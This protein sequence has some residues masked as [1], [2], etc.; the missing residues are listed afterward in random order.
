MTKGHAAMKHFIGLDAHSKT[1]MFVAVDGRGRQTM[2]QRVKTGE[3]AILDV[4]R[5]FSGKKALTFEESHLSKWLYTLLKPEVDDLVVCD[6]AYVYRKKGPKDDYPDTLHLAQQLRGNF[7]EPVFHEDN[8]FS[9][10]RNEVSAYVDLVRDSVRLKNRYK[11]LFRGEAIETKGSKIYRLEDRIKEISSQ[12]A[13]FVAE[14]LFKRIEI[15]EEQRALY[16]SRFE[17]YAGKYPEIRCLATIP[18]IA[19]TRASIIA[20]IVCS[21]R[22]FENKH[23]FWAYCMLVKYDKRSDD[24]SYGKE[25]TRGNRILKDVFMGAAESVLQKGNALK[26]IY[27][28]TKSKGLDHRAAKKNLARR[29]AAIALAVM[30]RRSPYKE[31]ENIET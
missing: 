28:D 18:G 5:S 15:F 29:I 8:F 10:L 9:D 31:Q 21:P 26:Q 7:L 4:V 20:A 1:C 22:R 25:K 13:R 6:P 2:A 11:A 23:R 12:S 30:K 16:S 19:E 24:C 17:E 3:K 14:G 27:D